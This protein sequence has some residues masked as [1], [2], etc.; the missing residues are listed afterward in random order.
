[1]KN[2]SSAPS[3]FGYLMENLAGP[4]RLE[5]HTEDT[6]RASAFMDRVFG[7]PMLYDAVVCGDLASRLANWW[8]NTFTPVFYSAH[9][10]LF[11]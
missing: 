2:W 3:Q 9:E 7:I 4:F 6:N 11:T 8:T 10:P 1:M 5:Q